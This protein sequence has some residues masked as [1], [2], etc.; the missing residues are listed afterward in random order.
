MKKSGFTLAE[1]LITLAVIGV[2]AA[3]TIPAVVKNY[4]ATELKTQFKKAYSDAAQAVLRMQT[5][6]GGTAYDFSD[7]VTVFRTKFMGYFSVLKDCT[8]S[9][10]DPDM[11]KTYNRNSV[12]TSLFI[13][14]FIVKNGMVYNFHKGPN[15]NNIYITVDI[16]GFKKG[17]NLWG[18]DVFTFYVLP[19][20]QV[21]KPCGPGKPEGSGA[22]CNKN[23]TSGYNGL[24]C[25]EV[26]LTDENYFKNLP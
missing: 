20:N 7:S 6:E 21:L 23:S 17:P 12:N 25:A 2:V 10:F 3:L 22:V 26:A 18:H 16:N 5:S 14:S 8:S 11:Y 1:V 9:C 24:G 15:T 4:K 19:S 13:R